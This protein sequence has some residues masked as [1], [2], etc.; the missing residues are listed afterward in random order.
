MKIYAYLIRPGA[1][2]R[3]QRP[4]QKIMKQYAQGAK[5]KKKNIPITARN[6]DRIFSLI[7]QTKRMNLH[8]RKQIRAKIV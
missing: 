6:A 3:I 8:H 2:F 5:K 4:H 7:S 1:G